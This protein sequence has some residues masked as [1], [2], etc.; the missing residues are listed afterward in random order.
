MG[1]SGSRLGHL[2][3][4]CRVSDVILGVLEFVSLGRSSAKEDLC[5]LSELRHTFN[6][7]RSVLGCAQKQ[8]DLAAGCVTGADQYRTRLGLGVE[9]EISRKP[10]FSKHLLSFCRPLLGG[11]RLALFLDLSS[12]PWSG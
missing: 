8:C 1:F 9:L 3:R 11:G 7:E 10:Y 2:L 12:G 4:R 5:R 6:A